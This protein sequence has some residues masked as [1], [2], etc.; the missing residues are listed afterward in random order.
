MTLVAHF[1]YG[2]LMSAVGAVAL[3]TGMLAT[4]SI[5]FPAHIGLTLSFLVFHFLSRWVDHDSQR[6]L[7]DALRRAEAADYRRESLANR[8]PIELVPVNEST[9]RRR[10]N[11]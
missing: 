6:R 2:A 5:L 11:A 8:E 7:V 1:F 4:D 10:A 9:L 3:L